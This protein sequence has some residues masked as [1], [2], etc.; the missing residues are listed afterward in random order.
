MRRTTRRTKIEHDDTNE[1]NDG[2]DHGDNNTKKDKSADKSA[3][4]QRQPIVQTVGS[5]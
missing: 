2:N 1:E 5:Q 4:I 3:E